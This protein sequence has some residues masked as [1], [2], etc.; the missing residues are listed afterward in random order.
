ML[1][2]PFYQS[3]HEFLEFYCKWSTLHSIILL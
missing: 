1:F 2:R 3:K